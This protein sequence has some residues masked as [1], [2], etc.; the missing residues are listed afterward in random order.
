MNPEVKTSNKSIRQEKNC[1]VSY[2]YTFPVELE[3]DIP[4]LPIPITMKHI[5]TM[6]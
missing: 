5:D 1:C 4:R 6:I 3:L 2:T